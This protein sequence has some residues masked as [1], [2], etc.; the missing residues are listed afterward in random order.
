MRRIIACGCLFFLP[1]CISLTHLQQSRPL[2]N[3]FRILIAYIVTVWR[4]S[5]FYSA[6]VDGQK[7]RLTGIDTP[8]SK[9]TKALGDSGVQAGFEGDNAQKEAA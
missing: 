8:E 2:A 9:A 6:S 3:T 7:V 5:F 1:V 4:W